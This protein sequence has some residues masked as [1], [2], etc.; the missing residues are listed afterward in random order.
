MAKLVDTLIQQV[1]SAR[2]GT[3]ILFREDFAKKFQFSQHLKMIFVPSLVSTSSFGFKHFFFH[4]LYTCLEE[5]V[6]F[7]VLSVF[8]KNAKLQI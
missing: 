7:V 5:H 4:F 8:V 6:Q 3:P 2:V 1:S